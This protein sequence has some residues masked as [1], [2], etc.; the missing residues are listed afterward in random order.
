MFSGIV[1]VVPDTM[2]DLT[3]ALDPGGMAVG[4]MDGSSLDPDAADLYD[5]NEIELAGNEEVDPWRYR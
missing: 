2:N 3:D 5:S 1:S 4:F